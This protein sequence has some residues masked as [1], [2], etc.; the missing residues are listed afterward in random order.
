MV[1]E[2]KT[3]F[4]DIIVYIHNNILK[5]DLNIFKNEISKLINLQDDLSKIF[6]FNTFPLKID[7]SDKKLYLFEPDYEVSLLNWVLGAEKTSKFIRCQLDTKESYRFKYLSKELTIS[8]SILIGI[9]ALSDPLNI[10]MNR[11]HSTNKQDSGWFIG[12]IDSSLDYNDVSNIKKISLYE[13]FC[14]D[15]RI[16]WFIDFPKYLMIYIKNNSIIVQKGESII[17]PIKG[18]FVDSYS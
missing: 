12:K 18:S 8:N 13:A 1:V 14:I 4:G 2:I 3:K 17:N 15:F 9:D 7:I 10:F 5:N 11:D 6:F 16:S